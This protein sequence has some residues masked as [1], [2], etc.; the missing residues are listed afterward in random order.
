[1]HAALTHLL[2]SSNELLC[3]D[4]YCALASMIVV[5]FHLQQNKQCVM[6]LPFASLHEKQCSVA[7]PVPCAVQ[8]LQSLPCMPFHL[9]QSP[10]L[11]SSVQ[12]QEPLIL[13][14]TTTANDKAPFENQ[15]APITNQ[16]PMTNQSPPQFHKIYIRSVEVQTHK[17]GHLSSETAVGAEY[18]M[19]E[20]QF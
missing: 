14:V 12:V 10:S 18:D 15:M 11:P 7:M 19:E 16:S 13:S 6:E 5:M 1:M 4:R 2:Q 20:V 3:Y 8:H 9:L 17:Q